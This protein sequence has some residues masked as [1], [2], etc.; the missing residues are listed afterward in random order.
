MMYLL[1]N[2]KLPGYVASQDAVDLAAPK[3]LAKINDE[4]KYDL[5]LQAPTTLSSH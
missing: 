4:M 5:S 3:L 1:P 2:I